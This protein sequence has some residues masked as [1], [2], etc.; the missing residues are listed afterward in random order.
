MSSLTDRNDARRLW[1][2]HAPDGVAEN[3]GGID[4]RP[5]ADFMRLSGLHVACHYPANPT[6]LFQERFDSRVIDRH[7]AQILQRLRQADGQSGIVELP[8]EISYAP[9]QTAGLQRGQM[10]Q[11]FLA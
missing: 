8:V 4:N 9:A 7:S 5:S 6:I 11:H 3:S 2:V 10:F 1:I